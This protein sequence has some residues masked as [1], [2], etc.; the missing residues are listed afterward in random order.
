[1]EKP[2][3]VIIAPVPK[4]HARRRLT[5]FIRQAALLGLLFAVA[6]TFAAVALK[7][8]ISK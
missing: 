7:T 8:L 4:G 2:P 5:S 1:M 6:G 3:G